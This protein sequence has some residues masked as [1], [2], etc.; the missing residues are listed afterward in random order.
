[1][2]DEIIRN[3]RLIART[4][5]NIYSLL[6]TFRTEVLS[7][8]D[9]QDEEIQRILRRLDSVAA[10]LD[11][12]LTVVQ[13]IETKVDTLV[14]N[15]ATLDT[16]VDGLIT[17]IGVIDTNVTSVETK[18]NALTTAGTSRD[19][20]I[21]EI[22]TELFLIQPKVEESEQQIRSALATRTNNIRDQVQFV[23]DR[24]GD[25]TDAPANTTVMSKLDTIVTNTTP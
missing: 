4:A 5:G 25:F 10:T 23:Q 24:L 20:E 8:L 19:V 9:T 13:S 15:V 22:K 21:G 11:Q 2:N 14:T 3:L 7:R 12:V 17:D 16:K 1:M 6:N 18:V